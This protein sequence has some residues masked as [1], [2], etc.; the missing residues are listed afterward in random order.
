MIKYLPIHG[1]WDNAATIIQQ[2]ASNLGLVSPQS[3]NFLA[4]PQV[5][6]QNESIHTTRNNSTFWVLAIRRN[7]RQGPDKARVA[8][9]YSR[10]L[11]LPPIGRT[12]RPHPY[13][14]VPGGRRNHITAKDANPPN[15]VVTIKLRQKTIKFCT[16]KSS[17]VTV[18]SHWSTKPQQKQ[19]S[20]SWT[21]TKE[22]RKAYIVLVAT[23]LTAELIHS[24]IDLH[25]RTILEDLTWEDEGRSVL[26]L[27]LCE[28]GWRSCCGSLP[29]CPSS[30]AGRASATECK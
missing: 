10:G 28:W 4:S 11:I 22:P 12:Q 23:E 14:P 7:P 17:T 5:P 18:S 21:K 29:S 3:L 24:V 13:C 9:Q 27:C 20:W 19:D 6:D 15:L 25:R 1:R 2:N 8:Q 16:F 26:E 30:R